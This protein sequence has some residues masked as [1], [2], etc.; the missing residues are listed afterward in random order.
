MAIERNLILVH[1]PGCQDRRD[2][3]AIARNVSELA[4]DIEAFVA[5]N[6]I[7]SSVTRRQASRRPT[8]IFSP[9]NLIEFRPLRGKIYAGSP[10]PKLEQMS[11]LKSAGISVPAFAEIT[12]DIVLSE[13]KFASHVVVKPGF[14]LSSHGQD[15]TLMRRTSVSYRSRESFPEDHPGRHGPM[16]VQRFVDTGLFV[17]HYRVLTLFGTPLLA[18]KNTSKIARPPLDVSDEALALIAVKARRRASMA[19]T[20]LVHEADVLALASS[21]YRALPEIP[22]HGV[23]VIREATTGEL[24]V[25]EVTPGGN[26]W[27]FSKGDTPVR[28][29]KALGVDSLTEQFDAFTTAARVLIE[30]TR[31]EA[32]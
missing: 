19:Q 20:Q 32:A 15:I 3:E 6:E 2:F 12:P 10:I 22:L 9:G 26:T 18:Y 31:A 17:S 4:P 30:R 16:F 25:L 29:K 21:T 8:L 5:S 13:G 23:D 27:S 1:Q 14:S 28:L 7:P 11:R 24:F